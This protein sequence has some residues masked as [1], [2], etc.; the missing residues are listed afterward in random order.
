VGDE[1]AQ[2]AQVGRLTEPSREHETLQGPAFLHR[3]PIPVGHGSLY[4]SQLQFT[5]SPSTTL[6]QPPDT[7]AHLGTPKRQRGPRR[8]PGDPHT[9]HTCL[10]PPAR[11]SFV[12]PPVKSHASCTHPH[13]P[14][15]WRNGHHRAPPWNRSLRSSGRRGWLAHCPVPWYGTAR[16]AAQRGHSRTDSLGGRAA[17]EGVEGM[18]R[19]LL[20]VSSARSGNYA[21][22]AG[23]W[24]RRAE[25]ARFTAAAAA[26]SGVTSDGR[27]LWLR[28]GGSDS[29]IVRAGMLGRAGVGKGS[30]SPVNV[31]WEKHDTG[32]YCVSWVGSRSM[33]CRRHWGLADI[34]AMVR[35]RAGSVRD[36]RH[37]LRAVRDVEFWS[38]QMI[39]Q[40]SRGS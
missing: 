3:R 36:G 34:P 38:L 7:V 27:L 35:R 26:G 25:S 16:P 23:G 13:A 24:L 1:C 40:N 22:R 18:E 10:Y 19:C 11:A 31:A 2:P 28:V 30:V 8:P 21:R 17:R 39:H 5:T 33:C 37:V 15:I 6:R 32:G 4:L 14:S 20:G 9:A 12:R 29:L